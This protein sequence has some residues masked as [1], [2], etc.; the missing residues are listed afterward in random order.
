LLVVLHLLVPVGLLLWTWRGPD[1][2][3][4]DWAARVLLLLGYGLFIY[5]VGS[6]VFASFYIRYALILMTLTVVARSILT[7]KEM[8]L[9]P[10]GGAA[11]WA[12]DGLMAVAFIV[13]AFLSANA[14]RARHFVSQALSLSF[15]FTHGVYGV[16]EGGDGRKSVLMNYHFGSS[17]HGH[18]GVNNS[19]K[20]AVDMT[21]LSHWG[22]DAKGFLSKQRERYPIFN[23][24]LL[25]PCEGRVKGV[26]DRWP[27]EEPWSGRGPYNLGNYVLI[28][29]GN[30]YVLMGHL[31]QGSITVKEGQRVE[32]G[33]P[34]A[35]AGNSGW[36][37]QPHLHIQ[38]MQISNDSFWNGEGVPIVF[39]GK[40]PYKNR[41]FFR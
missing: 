2:G 20:Y 8:P 15:P 4:V 21:K 31:Q 41:L 7:F 25:S 36:T 5:L 14:L 22:N 13:L 29:T 9:W 33:E 17:A 32:A 40:N 35:L 26:M 37:S 19:M 18:S 3:L 24:T 34:I 10:Q 6:W 12:G 27:N 1:S 39:D 30:Y 16:F 38:A 28:Q 11:F 23:A